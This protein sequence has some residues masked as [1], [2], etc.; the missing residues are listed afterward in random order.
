MIWNFAPIIFLCQDDQFWWGEGLQIRVRTGPKNLNS[1]S[2]DCTMMVQ[3]KIDYNS[4]IKNHTKKLMNSKICFR[5]LSLEWMKKIIFRVYRDDLKSTI[6][7][8]LKIAKIEKFSFSFVSDGGRV[9]KSVFGQG[10][11][12]WIR[13][14][15]T[16][17][18]WYNTRSTIT[19]KLKITQKN[20]WTQ[21]SVSDH[22]LWNGWKKLFLGCIEMIWNRPYLLN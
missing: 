5:S 1:S 14:V 10:Q 13:Q 3:Y 4:K 19:Q 11:K 17:L 9:C 8:K 6:S 15:L 12:F 16:A 7:P 20:S 2:P 18:W 22:C 21:K